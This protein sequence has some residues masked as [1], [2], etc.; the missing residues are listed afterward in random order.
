MDGWQFAHHFTMFGGL[1]VSPSISIQEA[2][3]GTSI[4]VP[5]VFMGTPDVTPRLAIGGNLNSQLSY[6]AF[7]P[8]ALTVPQIYPAGNGT[9]PRNFIT[10]PG[11][12]GNDMTISKKFTIVEGK[13]LELRVSAYNAFN[14]VRRTTI[15]SSVQY[16]AQGASYSNGFVVYNTPDQLAARV[17]A[18]NNA[19]TVFN[20]YRTGVG[21]SNIL[22]VQPMRIMEL[23][24]KF[25]F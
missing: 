20:Q 24:L 4:S 19:L 9:G 13:T 10:Q 18:G 6:M 22:N 25:R 8:S 5:N 23:G 3:T 11:T 15:N 12:F 14:Q 17:A 7:N 21:Y 2:N 1:P 16:K